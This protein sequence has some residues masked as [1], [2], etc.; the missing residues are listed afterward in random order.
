MCTNYTHARQKTATVLIK[1]IN[2]G[3]KLQATTLKGNPWRKCNRQEIKMNLL[4]A[5]ENAGTYWKPPQGCSW[6][7]CCLG[8]WEKGR[9]ILGFPLVFFTSR[10]W[11]ALDAGV[12]WCTNREPPLGPLGRRIPSS[13]PC[14]WK[15]ASFILEC[16]GLCTALGTR[17]AVLQRWRLRP[18]Q[19]PSVPPKSNSL[20]CFYILASPPPI[21]A[22]C[23]TCWA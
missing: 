16:I 5:Q 1:Y 12:R 14:K 2:F 18:Q 8:N 15:S 20:T 19:Q 6:V 3:G 9:F 22:I 7:S 4:E 21:L 11:G 10:S 17:T 13:P 23:L